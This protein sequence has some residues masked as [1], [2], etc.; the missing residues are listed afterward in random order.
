MNAHGRDKAMELIVGGQYE[1]IGILE[2]SVLTTLGLHPSHNVIDVGCG[3]GR[4]PFALRDYL[5]GSFLGTDILDEALDYA[6]EKVKRPDWTFI[7]TFE[8]K[9]PTT[10]KEAD[11]TCFFSVFTHLLDED[12]F[13]FIQEAQR[14]TK[15]GGLIVFSY[16]DF[17]VP[18]HW[19]VFQQTLANVNPNRVLNKFISKPAIRKWAEVL[20][21][22]L[23]HLYDGEE[24]WIQLTQEFEYNDGR[25]AKGCVGFGQSIAVLKV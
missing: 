19:T 25:V 15:E 14:V 13:R 11:F 5:K 2:K 6:K 20:G 1:Q 21:L 22:T 18:S 8:T 9:I 10:E 3:S 24:S 17:E 4:L 16:L 7:E 23:V 12:I